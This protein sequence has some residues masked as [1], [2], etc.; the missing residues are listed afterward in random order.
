MVGWLAPRHQAHF[1]LAPQILS[2]RNEMLHARVVGRSCAAPPASVGRPD[3]TFTKLDATT[4]VLRITTW[5]PDNLNYTNFIGE[6]AAPA[7]PFL[8]LS[9]R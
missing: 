2:P 8:L 5:I 9:F 7:K 6:L 3:V 1:P 4:G